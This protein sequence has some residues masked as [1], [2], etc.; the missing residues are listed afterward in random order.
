MATGIRS[1]LQNI[2]PSAALAH[3]QSYD[4]YYHGEPEIRL[5]S[6]ICDPA[7]ISLD[8]GANIGTYT[9]FM[10]RYSRRVVAF[11]P[12]PHLAKQLSRRFPDVTV[13]ANACSD[14]SY[15]A[16]LQLPPLP[17]NRFLHEQGSIADKSLYDGAQRYDV[18]A[19]PLDSFGFED[20]GFL[21]IDAERHDREV[22]RGAIETIARCRP[23]IMIE[24]TPLLYQNPLP[25][26]FR[27]LTDLDYQ[28]WFRFRGNYYPFTDWR[29]ELHLSRV[30]RDHGQ[31]FTEPNVFFL[32]DGDPFG[33]AVLA[34]SRS[35]T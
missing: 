30:L 19:L 13:F 29:A 24:V 12:N 33:Q 10:R 17:D 15:A 9:Y 22:L 32:P 6:A 8:V 7:L 25:E 35:H 4:H 27:F 16:V 3:L 18:Q 26:E 5:L 2:L 1:I 20:V 14:R 28:G 21:K 34:G 11:E 31:G 23:R